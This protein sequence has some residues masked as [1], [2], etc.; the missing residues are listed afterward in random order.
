MSVFKKSC[1]PSRQDELDQIFE[2][3]R[4]RDV[5][6]DDLPRMKYLDR[7]VKEA[8]RIFPVVPIM[9]RS[10]LEDAEIDV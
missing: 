6:A 10:L 1:C 8:L 4:D 2:G 9:T 3:D 7:C 5:T